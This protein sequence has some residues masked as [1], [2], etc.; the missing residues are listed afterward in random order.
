M[1]PVTALGAAGSVVGIASFGLQLC[2]ALYQFTAEA[3]S[4]NE[5]LVAVLS[6]I[7]ATTL[8]LNQVHGFLKEEVEH[9]K[10]K[11]QATFFSPTSI[12]AVKKTADECLVIFWKI[13]ATIAHKSH[14]NIEE[15]LIAKLNE[16]NEALIKQESPPPII[17]DKKLTS[18][19][20]WNRLRW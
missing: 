17:T 12:N 5:S 15:K 11:K 7:Q 8:A 6:G 1:D 3:K 14:S 9:L 16:F 20:I 18:M 2:Q 19:S 4:A 13:E 10:T